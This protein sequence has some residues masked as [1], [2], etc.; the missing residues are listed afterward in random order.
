MMKRI[1]VSLCALVMLVVTLAGALALETS[2]DGCTVQDRSRP[3]YIGFDNSSVPEDMLTYVR[4]NCSTTQ[5]EWVG[6]VNVSVL[7]DV[8]PGEVVVTETSVFV[9]TYLRPDLDREA[10]LVFT[11]PPFAVEPNVLRNGVECVVCNVTWDQGAK[12]L[13]VVVPGFSNY[14]LTGQKDFTVYS[15]QEP[16]LYDKVYQTIDLGDAKRAEEYKCVVQIYGRN[17]NGDFILVQTNPQR[18]VQAKLWGSPDPNQPESL[19]YFKTESGLANVY[20]DGSSLDGYEAFQYV[21]QC[22][23]NST[24]LIYEE[25]IDTRYRAAGR[26]M[27][28]RGVWFASDGNGVYIVLAL[29]VGMVLVW[30]IAMYLRS[31]WKV[32]RGY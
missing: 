7:G 22:A 17:Q 16:E 31:V 11:K 25:G 23:N 15:D 28:G 10:V 1:I 2:I 5:V 32:L 18:Q 8:L 29:L 20:F 27:I 4:S 24:K 14:S 6:G 13:E 30:L 19:G 3:L 26:T 9:D 21:A 12:V